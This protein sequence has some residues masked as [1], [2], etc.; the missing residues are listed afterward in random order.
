MF[1]DDLYKYAIFLSFK[2]FLDLFLDKTDR[3]YV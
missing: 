3:D 2:M 1:K